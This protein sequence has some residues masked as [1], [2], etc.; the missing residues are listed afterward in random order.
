MVALSLTC[1][2]GTEATWSMDEYIRSMREA[3][4]RSIVLLSGCAQSPQ[5]V[6]CHT[7]PATWV[8]AKHVKWPVSE[9]FSMRSGPSKTAK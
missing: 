7:R 3:L 2:A 6:E 5:H 1:H 8:A 9:I 4:G